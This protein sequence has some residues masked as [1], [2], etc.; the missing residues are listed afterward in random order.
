MRLL[1]LFPDPWP[2]FRPDL[3]VLFGKYLPRY[4]LTTDIAT[5]GVLCAEAWRGGKAILYRLPRSKSL[6]HVAKLLQNLRILLKVDRHAYGA[7]QLRGMPIHAL[8]GLV[9]ARLKGL[10]FVYWFSFPQSEAQLFRASKM[11]PGG[12]LLYWFLLAQGHVGKWLLYGIVLPRADHVFVQSERMKEDVASHGIRANKMTAVPMGVDIEAAKVEEIVPAD[13]ARLSGKRVAI[14][15]GTLDRERNVELLL[16]MLALARSREPDLVLVMAGDTVHADYS[17]Q[18]KRLAENLGVTDAVIW[19]GWLSTGEA[20]RYVRAA[21]VGLSPIPRGILFDCS[22]PTKLIEYM[23]LG[24][25]VIAN[26]SPDQ[27]R[28]IRESGAGVCVDL[29]PEAFADALLEL[30]KDPGRLGSMGS[31]GRSYAVGVRSYDRLA[32]E[33]AAVYR[34]LMPENGASNGMP[35]TG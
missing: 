13:D 8:I 16:E 4:G 22:S 31:R 10:R 21:E 6:G 17:M 24:V 1:Y 12:G 25:P 19:T 2:T 3:A 33:V 20:W 9:V 30:L 35:A 11:G 14:Y 27:E 15:L 28:V 5:H 23:A 18:L 29:S 32:S 7:I 26:D 34:R